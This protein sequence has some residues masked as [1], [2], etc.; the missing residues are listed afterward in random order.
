MFS[1]TKKDSQP[2][3]WLSFLIC[4][5][6]LVLSAPGYEADERSSL[7]H[8]PDRR[9]WRKEGGRSECR[10][11]HKRV[12]ASADT[13]L[14]GHR[15]RERTHSTQI[16]IQAKHHPASATIIGRNYDTKS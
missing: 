3:G 11:R 4:G 6:E 1:R 14:A 15:K 13:L 8:E 16:L 2:F 12:S 7:G 10:G 5:A 9:R